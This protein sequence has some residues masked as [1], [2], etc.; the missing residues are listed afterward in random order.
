LLIPRNIIPCVISFTT[1]SLR[2]RYV[3]AVVLLTADR[4]NKEK[5]A[6]MFSTNTSEDKKKEVLQTL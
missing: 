1:L 4:I 6:I 3:D 5:L 2:R